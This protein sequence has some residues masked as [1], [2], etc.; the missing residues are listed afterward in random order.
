[1]QPH[2]VTAGFEGVT[3]FIDDRKVAAL[4]MRGSRRIDCRMEPLRRK[5]RDMFVVRAAVEITS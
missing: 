4:L 5:R 3:G 2:P 1:M